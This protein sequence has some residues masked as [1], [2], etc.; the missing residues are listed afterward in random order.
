MGEARHQDPGRAS[1]FPR[2]IPLF[3]LFPPFKHTPKSSNPNPESEWAKKPC[4]FQLLR[5]RHH[6][7]PGAAWRMD[8][9]GAPR[10]FMPGPA[11]PL[12]KGHTAPCMCGA[13]H[14]YAPSSDIAADRAMEKCFNCQVRRYAALDRR[15][16]DD[17]GARRDALRSSSSSPTHRCPL[18]S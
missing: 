11:R 18:S 14:G 13:T 17:P 8:T 4:R 2:V 12:K 7:A 1:D 10:P 5:H 9:A 15:G 3:P 16:P 6:L